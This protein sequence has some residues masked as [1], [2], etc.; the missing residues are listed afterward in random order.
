MSVSTILDDIENLVVDAKRMPL[1][2]SIFI[3]ESD[4]VRLLDNLR[5]ELPNELANA[6][7]I[8]D[9]RDE[10]LN[11]ARGEA[12]QIISRA[13]DTAEEMIDESRIVQ[14]SK[15][16]AELIMEQTKGQAKELYDNSYQQARQ[17]RLDANNYANQVFD[18]LILNVGNALEVLKQAR[19][20]LQKMPVEPETP[21]AEPQP[22]APTEL[23]EA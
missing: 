12:E 18:H 14:A 8:M 16:K 9:S 20:E 7:E 21:P 13:K 1:T 10:I 11:H 2:N 23:P 15:E 3:S 4:L 22:M 17:L 5:Q 19:D 6:Q